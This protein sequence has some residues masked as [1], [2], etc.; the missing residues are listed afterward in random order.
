MPMEASA[1]G[2]PF[3]PRGLRRRR[4]LP[5]L[6]CLVDVERDDVDLALGAG[7]HGLDVLKLVVPDG[8]EDVV[9]VVDDGPA[10]VLGGLGGRLEGVAAGWGRDR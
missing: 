6:L 3:Q 8:L 1:T 2:A 10:A 5:P 7:R 4:R 9:Q